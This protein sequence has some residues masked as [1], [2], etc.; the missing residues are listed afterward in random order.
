M[1]STQITGATTAIAAF[2]PQPDGTL[3]FTLPEGERTVRVGPLPPGIALK[4]MTYGTVDLQRAPLK[5]EANQPATELRIILQKTQP[6]PWV[7][8]A[9]KVTGL[10][11]EVRNLRV[12]LTGPFNGPLSVPVNPDGTFAFD[13]VFQGASS[14][15]LLGNIGE[16]LQPPVNITVGPKD[17]TDVEIVYRR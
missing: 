15:R 16:P 3:R 6:Q 12:N 5:I 4:S 10:P 14:V 2:T 1:F 8:V 13:Q 9:G 17:I 11:A 7:R